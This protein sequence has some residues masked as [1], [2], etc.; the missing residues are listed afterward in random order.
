MFRL[1]PK[2]QTTSSPHKSYTAD[3]WSYSR[4]TSFERCQRSFYH[5]YVEGR[6]TPSSAPMMTG[7]I[8]HLAIQLMITEGYSPDEAIS[9]AVYQEG[10][11]PHGEKQTFI[12]WM[13]YRVYDILPKDS[14]VD[15]TSELHL[16]VKTAKGLVQGYLDIII[17]D[18]R[19]NTTEIWD[20]KTGWTTT[21]AEKSRQLK[22]YAYL[23]HQMRRGMVGKNFIGKLIFPRIKEEKEM[24]SSL[25][26]TQDDMTE[27]KEWLEDT[28]TTIEM[29]NALNRLDW[30]KT[31][32]RSN[33]QTCPFVSLCAGDYIHDLPSDGIP[34]DSLEAELIGSFILEQEQVLRNLKSG[35]KKWVKAEG[36]ITVGNG[37]WFMNESVPKP[38]VD[39]EKLA[40]YAKNYDLNLMEVIK[41]DTQSVEKWLKEDENGD[42]EAIVTWTKPR[43]TLTFK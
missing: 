38:K 9:Y 5:K 11:L 6:P 32:E 17:D 40:I 10:E 28:I 22:V 19:T 12:E 20:F 23:F 3:V 8:F 39:V 25:V 16:E 37:Q 34:K 29:K 26:I 18:P 41:P 24:I 21:K 42:L 31:K 2:E 15:V 13:L 35:L 27:A 4:L 14:Y 30:E 7:K 36:N 33:C 43:E 1:F